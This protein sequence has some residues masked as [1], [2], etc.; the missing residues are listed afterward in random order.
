MCFRT[1]RTPSTLGIEKLRAKCYL[2]MQLEEAII[3]DMLSELAG[4]FWQ[5]DQRICLELSR[6]MSYHFIHG[7]HSHV[8]DLALDQHGND[9]MAFQD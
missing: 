1:C 5:V 3:F 6:K 9:L 8:A 4:K 2:R 7:Q